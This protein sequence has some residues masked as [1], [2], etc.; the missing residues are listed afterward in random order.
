M[1][2]DEYLQNLSEAGKR[3]FLAWDKFLHEHVDF[4]HP[5]S[6]IHAAPHCERVLF[7]ALMLAEKE[8][9]QDAEAREIVA[10]A[11]VFHDTRRFDDYL[12]VGHGARAAAHYKEYCQRHPACSFH[13]ESV[14]L[15]RY[16]DLDD[17]LGMEAI[18]KDF[19]ASAPRVLQLYAIFKDADALDRWRLGRRGLN[20]KYLRSET[21][22]ALTEFSRNV[23]KHS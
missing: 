6:P 21:A 14:Y 19:G 10:H 16:H 1:I 23:V 8:L 13:P 4:T 20:P 15:M 3:D 9:P 12:D 18:K 11:A 22:K 17:Q 5:E 7:F 2:A